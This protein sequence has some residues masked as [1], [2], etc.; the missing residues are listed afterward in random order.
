MVLK[1]SD[2]GTVPPFLVMDV[3]RSA[4]ELEAKG[5]HILHMEIGQPS[6][7]LPRA[8]ADR[9]GQELAGDDP[10]GYTMAPGI[11]ELR[12][13]IAEHGRAVYG[14]DIDPD[15]VFCT[16]GSSAGFLMAFLTAFEPGDRVGLAAPGYPAYRHILK[17][18]GLEPV[19]LPT[20]PESR[21]QPTIKLLQAVTPAL[22][23]LIVASPSNP[24]G[25]MLPPEDMQALAE[26]CHS[27][28]IRLVSD[29]I[30]HGIS[31]GTRAV[32]ASA[33]S[34]SAVVINSFSKYYCMTGWRLGWMVLPED[35]VRPVECLAQNLFISAPTIS[36]VAACHV[37]DCCDEL[38]HIVDGYA[39]NRDEV[40]SGLA[41]AGITRVAPPDG[42]FYVYA[43]I[44]HT[45][46]DSREFSRRMLT[47]AGVAAAPGWD[48]DPDRGGDFIRFSYAGSY[49]TVSEAMARL[50]DWVSTL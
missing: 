22:D 19:L 34:P 13:R 35:L 41:R 43:D 46:I 14:T 12:Q 26:Y 37:F 7:R 21:F 6:Q 32:T 28:G 5:N 45:G 16:M 27:A 31:Y 15:R 2:R 50:K 20:G 36:Q 47:E 25:S 38:D 18:V 42:A 8:V 11:P 1:V 4:A 17:S 30:Y 23:G 24:T 10:M 3:L 9:V 33:F 40:I 49:E 44:S 48:F 29:E 39:R